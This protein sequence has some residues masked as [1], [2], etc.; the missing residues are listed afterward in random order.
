VVSDILFSIWFPASA[1]DAGRRWQ[2]AYPRW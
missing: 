1:A 2:R